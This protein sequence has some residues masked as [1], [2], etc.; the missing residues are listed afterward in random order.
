[1]PGF[2]SVDPVKGQTFTLKTPE[3]PEGRVITCLNDIK[4]PDELGRV[5]G[6]SGAHAVAHN[7]L[8]K[9]MASFASVRDPAFLLWHFG[10]IETSR[11]EW[12]NTDS[13]KAWQKDHPSGW[14]DPNVDAG[15][16]KAMPKGEAAKGMRSPEKMPWGDD[17]LREA[18]VGFTDPSER[19]KAKQR[20]ATQPRPN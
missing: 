9:E 12:L 10:V 2:L 18:G 16:V 3:N 17:E 14:T 6:E 7:K 11:A 15:R 8:G 4:N 20:V 1:M 5:W 13:G 19:A